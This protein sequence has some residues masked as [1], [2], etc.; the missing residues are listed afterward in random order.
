MV[1]FPSYVSSSGMAIC[2]GHGD[3]HF[4]S[5]DGRKFDYQGKCRYILL[6]SVIEDL[7]TTFTVVAK[8]RPAL[9]NRRVALTEELH[10]IV[11]NVVN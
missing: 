10:I 9:R 7:N 5:F 4:K 3:P 1:L 11:D 8:H 6:R 2:T